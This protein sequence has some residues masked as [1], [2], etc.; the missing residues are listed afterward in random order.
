M[1]FGEMRKLVS[2]KTTPD[3]YVDLD[4]LKAFAKKGL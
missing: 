3:E 2:G 4:Y 1:A